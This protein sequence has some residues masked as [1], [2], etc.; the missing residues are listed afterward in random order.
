[1]V[2][3]IAIVL[4]NYVYSFP[5]VNGEIPSGRSSISGG[6]MELNEAQDLANI[7]KAGKLPA[8]ARIVEEAVVGPSLGREAVS[9]GMNSFILAFILVLAYMIVYYN[10]AGLVANFCTTY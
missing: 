10:R 2:K 4:D 8:P 1:L 5:V 6:A 9:S 3:Q 7:L